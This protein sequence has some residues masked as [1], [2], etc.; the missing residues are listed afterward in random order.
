MADNNNNN[1]QVQQNTVPQGQ[2]QGGQPQGGQSQGNQPDGN[3]TAQLMNVIVEMQKQ[4]A[5]L[6]GKNGNNGNNGDDNDPIKMSQNNI[7]QQKLDEANAKM[8]EDCIKFNISI[9]N[10]VEKYK[11][12]LPENT[13]GML[14]IIKDTPFSNEIEKSKN[15][16]MKMLDNFFQYKDNVELVKTDSEMRKL[17]EYKALASQDRLNKSGEYWEILENA[18]VVKALL[19]KA[20]QVG[21]SQNGVNTND[22]VAHYNERFF[23]ANKNAFGNS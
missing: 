1:G 6:S 10:F 7:N 3:S 8:V 20:K 16:K 22:T 4:I 15:L 19:E 17:N 12:L 5:A 23:K 21:M 13:A 9:D 14:K 18:L 11:K 2:T